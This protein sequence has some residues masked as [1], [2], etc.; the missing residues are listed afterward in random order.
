MLTTKQIVEIEGA[1]S[2]SLGML[3]I[4][5]VALSGSAEASEPMEELLEYLG[6][7]RI[8]LILDNL[9]T[10]LDERLRGFL[11]RLPQGSKVL[12]TSRVGVGAY[13]H[14]LKLD[15]LSNDE[16][17]QLLRSL[18]KATGLTRLLNVP[19][20]VVA[21]YCG[22]MKNNP[23]FIKWFVSAVQA[24]ARPEEVLANPTP[25]LDFCISN[26]Y[27]FLT[28]ESRRILQTLQ[29]VSGARSQAELAFL[30]GLDSVSLQR[31]L[32]Q[33]LTTNMVNMLPLSRGSSF[34][35]TYDLS[36]LARDYLARAHPVP[37][38]VA[39]SLKERRREL[40]KA[41]GEIAAGRKTNE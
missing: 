1:I 21:G 34:R 25:F 10:V 8:L 35:S 32:Q 2:D 29:Y 19:N 3:R 23:G 13:E 20:S 41:S 6:S 14:P 17:V 40:M 36:E 5:S 27:K 38:D 16:A 4:A 9:E 39:R 18:T 30:S 7:F 24:G 15:P 31:A 26:V 33:V 22:Q 11:A 28:G 12:I 37:H